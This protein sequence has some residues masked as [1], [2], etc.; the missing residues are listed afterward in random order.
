MRDPNDIDDYVFIY[1]FDGTLFIILLPNKTLVKTFMNLQTK[2][3][4][5]H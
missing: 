4:K 5:S 1:D 3:E 2:Q